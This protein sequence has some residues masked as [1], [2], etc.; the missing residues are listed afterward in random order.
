MNDDDTWRA[1]PFSH[2]AFS[3][4][5]LVAR[6]GGTMRVAPLLARSRL[7]PRVLVDAINEL[8]ERGWV[9]IEWRNPRRRMPDGTPECFRTVER[10]TTTAFGRWRYS[11]TWPTD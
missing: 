5:S 2:S 9:K 10:I 6:R 4:F 11:V 1:P 3:V 7:P 8:A